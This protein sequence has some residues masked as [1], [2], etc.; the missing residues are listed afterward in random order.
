MIRKNINKYFV[1]LHYIKNN[2]NRKSNMI[3]HHG[4]MGSSKNFKS[5]SKNQSISTYVN[6]YL[7]DCR[8]HG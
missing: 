2:F 6:S 3:I 1:S 5:I 8:N 4:L 7:I